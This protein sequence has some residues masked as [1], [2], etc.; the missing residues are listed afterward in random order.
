MAKWKYFLKK[1]QEFEVG[2]KKDTFVVLLTKEIFIPCIME[3]TTFS[4]CWVF[5]F[6][7]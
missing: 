2:K 4:Q 3:E 7:I 1:C 5:Y 6:E